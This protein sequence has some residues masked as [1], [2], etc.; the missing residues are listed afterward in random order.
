MMFTTWNITSRTSQGSYH[1]KYT[2]LC[3]EE[4]KAKPSTPKY[5]TKIPNHK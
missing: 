3:N 4:N 1:M 5:L 2:N